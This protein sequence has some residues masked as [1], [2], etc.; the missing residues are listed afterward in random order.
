MIPGAVKL[1]PRNS[2]PAEDV[3]EALRR[4]ACAARSK[5]RNRNTNAPSYL[6]RA[7]GRVFKIEFYR[8]LQE[9]H[10]RALQPKLAPGVEAVVQQE[11]EGLDLL[12][13]G[14][15]LRSSSSCDCASNIHVAPMPSSAKRCRSGRGRR[16]STT[17]RCSW[18]AITSGRV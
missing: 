14:P 7:V 5:S 15:W 1:L 11:T 18:S 10:G 4:L 3:S 2:W 13:F 17:L 6:Q 8:R 9:S 12:G 16:R